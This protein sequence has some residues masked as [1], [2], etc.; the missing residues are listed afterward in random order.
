MLFGS[1]CQFCIRATPLTAACAAEG[2]GVQREGRSHMTAGGASHNQP[3][4]WCQPGEWIAAP[5]RE[6]THAFRRYGA[7]LRRSWSTPSRMRRLGCPLETGLQG[8]AA[9][10]GSSHATQ[11]RPHLTAGIF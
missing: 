11:R 2:V 8:P 7:R 4:W 1:F 6:M 10:N 9:A 3:D 5:R